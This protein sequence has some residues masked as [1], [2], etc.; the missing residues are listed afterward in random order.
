MASNHFTTLC[1][2]E[3]IA[4]PSTD[5][6]ARAFLTNAGA[7]F[8]GNT[9]APNCA[10]RLESAAAV[11]WA[12]THLDEEDKWVAIPSHA[13]KLLQS[14]FPIKA[15]I[16]RLGGDKWTPAVRALIRAQIT[17]VASPVKATAATGPAPGTRLGSKNVAKSLNA[18][19]NAAAPT[20]AAP[21]CAAPIPVAA[22]AQAP[23]APPAPQ[24]AVAAQPTSAA[25]TAAG[26]LV[27]KGNQ[28]SLSASQ[29]YQP[30]SALEAILSPSRLTQ[31]YLGESWTLEKRANRDKQMTRV[32]T[33]S[34]FE[35]RFEDPADPLWAQR[36]AFRR[37]TGS[38]LTP[39]AVNQDGRNLAL[40]LR[41]ESVEAYTTAGEWA[42]MQQLR[43]R[44]TRVGTAWERFSEAIDLQQGVPQSVIRPILMAIKEVLAL[45]VREAAIE[46]GLLGPAGQEI[47]DDMRR[48]Q[49]EVATLFTTYDQILAA[50]MAGIMSLQDMARR[51]NGV[52]WALLEPSVKLLCPDRTFAPEKDALVSQAE[53]ACAARPGSKR[54][55]TAV[56]PLAPSPLTTPMPPPTI[57]VPQH[58]FSPWSWPPP[59]ETPSTTT[60]PTPPAKDT[61]QSSEEEPDDEEYHHFSPAPAPAA[62][63]SA[64][65]QTM[66]V[67]YPAAA[68]AATAAARSDAPPFVV[69]YPWNLFGP[70]P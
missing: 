9:G 13:A 64:P 1:G 14:L 67:A 28:P 20:L 29:A 70:R 33:S 48:Q 57:T 12:R 60:L 11:A 15:S 8:S 43:D 59:A 55:K 2:T 25:T 16:A 68:A 21:I 36:I 7:T 32:Q 38:A 53:G 17:P 50:Q 30:S 37:G 65:A 6:D 5:K 41:W 40:A 49:T 69:L 39:E 51:T 58:I 63:P 35:T 47:V 54:P 62:V 10:I 31:L 3:K 66:D 23:L 42:A 4:I 34:H 27:S 18:A 44:A 22:A 56:A 24:T 45:R 52:W 46:V 19:L 61:T 26:P